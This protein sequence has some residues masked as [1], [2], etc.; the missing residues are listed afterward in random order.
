MLGPAL[1]ALVGATV[2]TFEQKTDW[3]LIALLSGITLGFEIFVLSA[4]HTYFAATSVL[5][6]LLWLTGIARMRIRPQTWSLGL[7]L[8]SLMIAPLL[9]SGLTTFNPQ[10]DVDLPRAGPGGGPRS[11]STLNPNQKKILDYV[12]ANTEPD[13]YLFATMDSHGASAFILAT[14]RPVFTF[15]GYVGKDNV[16]DVAGLQAMVTAGKLRFILDNNNLSGKPEIAA[17]IGMNCRVAEVPGAVPVTQQSVG[18]PRDQQF[19]ALYDCGK[20]P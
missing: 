5:M 15:G 14:A 19:K 8:I 10:P 11:D 12:T 16:I 4:G 20:Q 3:R 2:W 7:V 18:G 17:W 1:A 6:A 9:W 13:S